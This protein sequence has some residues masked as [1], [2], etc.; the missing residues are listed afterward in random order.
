MVVPLT[1]DPPR[2]VIEELLTHKGTKPHIGNAVSHLV[3]NFI[4]TFASHLK[5][6][7]FQHPSLEPPGLFINQTF[8]FFQPKIT[9]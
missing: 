9:V 1:P 6:F 2:W 7:L 5:Y 8:F 3:I 4:V